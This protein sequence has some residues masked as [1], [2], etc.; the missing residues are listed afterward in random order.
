MNVLEHLTVEQ[1]PSYAFVAGAHRFSALAGTAAI[2]LGALVLVGW[3]LDVPQLKGA[4]GSITMKPNAALL[5]VLVG[6]SIL[7]LR[8][9]SGR[10]YNRRLGMALGAIV[11]IIAALTLSQHVVGWNLG[12]DNLLFVERAGAAATT[13]PGR[14]GPPAST[15][16]M[17][18]GI[19]LLVVTGHRFLALAQFLC[20]AAVLWMLSAVTGYA[21]G[22][23]ALY[24][25]S[26]FT[27]IALHTAIGLMLL[28]LAT[29]ALRADEGLVAT[30]GSARESGILARRALAVVVVAPLAL[31]WIATKLAHSGSV[32][33][34]FGTALLVVSIILV[35]SLVIGRNAVRLD[36]VSRH[37]RAERQRFSQE[38]E[39]LLRQEHEARLAAEEATRLKD[40]FL[41][42]VSHELRTPLTA[43][44]GWASLMRNE[45]LDDGTR[46]AALET[47][48]RNAKIQAEL[49]DDILD[50]S[51]VIAGKLRLKLAPVVLSAVVDDAIETVRPA[52]MARRIRLHT[53][54]P[55]RDVIVLADRDRLQQIF[56]NL[57][58]NAVKFSNEDGLIGVEV[59]LVD[60]RARIAVR[61]NGR[62]IEADFLPLVFERFLQ[63]DGSRSRRHGGLGLGLAIARHLVELHGGTITAASDGAG[64]GA[65]FIVEL[66]L[67]LDGRDEI[68]SADAEAAP[69]L[70]ASPRASD[71]T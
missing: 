34:A 31:G 67:S 55:D 70:A 71:A 2:A 25:L 13:S 61:D 3:Q 16:F 37:R 33:F 24:A 66:P 30:F 49:V 8:A 43:I 28:A 21:Y 36:L 12:I 46:D 38:R 11:A 45:R 4:G 53:V 29:L 64:K 42:T 1:E 18:I 60:A 27:G 7:S 19:A 65:T 56:W 47:I 32:E 41:A 50:V 54:R 63:A 44:L 52:A 20:I 39:V 14:M 57:L 58:S 5:F 62:G 59:T 23:E 48:E 40:Q 51:G 9:P 35:V 15:S 17:F 22:A 10:P 68:A 6:A 26:R 69:L